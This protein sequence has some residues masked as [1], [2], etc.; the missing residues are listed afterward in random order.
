MS[1]SNNGNSNGE[2]SLERRGWM[3]CEI[4]VVEDK[5]EMREKRDRGYQ[6]GIGIGWEGGERRRRRGRMREEGRES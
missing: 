3:F 5:R 6:I 1:S 4:K 2:L